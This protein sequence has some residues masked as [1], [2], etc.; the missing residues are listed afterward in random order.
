MLYDCVVGTDKT[1]FSPGECEEG[2]W[3]FLAGKTVLLT[4]A[5]RGLG[6]GIVRQLC[7]TPHKPARVLLLARA[8][9]RAKVHALV[10]QGAGP[11]F[12]A[13]S[14]ESYHTQHP[15]AHAWQR[16]VEALSSTPPASNT[17]M[18]GR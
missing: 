4:G 11:Q 8:E 3:G 2:E 5:T 16:C 15:L 18:G 12:R 7:T 14:C 9:P 6:E 1:L 17:S 10:S 13:I